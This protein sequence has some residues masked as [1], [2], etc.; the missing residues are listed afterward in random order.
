MTKLWAAASNISD[1]SAALAKAEEVIAAIESEPAFISSGSGEEGLSEAKQDLSTLLVRI[2]KALVE[3][4]EKTTEPVEVEKLVKDIETDL[5]LS[6]N[7]KYVPEKFR[8]NA[9][10]SSITESLAVI[11][12]RSSATAPGR[13]HSEDEGRHRGGRYGRRL[14]RATDAAQRVSGAGR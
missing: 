2:G 12:T 5:A 4:A 7:T 3:K 11:R 13:D 9:E 10:L 14:R 8:N 6:A 1:P